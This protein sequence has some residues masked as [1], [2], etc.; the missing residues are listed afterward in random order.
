MA[1]LP[2]RNLATVHNLIPETDRRVFKENLKQSALGAA[3]G[4]AI[5]FA[6]IPTVYVLMGLGLK[7]LYSQSKALYQQLPEEKRGFTSHPVTQVA[8]NAAATFAGF[9]VGK[10]VGSAIQNNRQFVMQASQ[11]E[12]LGP[13]LNSFVKFSTKLPLIPGLK[14]FEIVAKRSWAGL[15]ACYQS[16]TASRWEKL[17]AGGLHTLNLIFE[18]RNVLLQAAQSWYAHKTVDLLLGR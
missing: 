3:T 15:K 6:N 1:N 11:E 7:S 13:H 5:V 2:I 17:K 18:G 8:C 4:V 16:R 9:L 10:K 14:K 12:I